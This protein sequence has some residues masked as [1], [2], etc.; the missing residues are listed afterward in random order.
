M[1]IPILYYPSMMPYHKTNSFIILNG[2]ET[3]KLPSFKDLCFDD[4]DHLLVDS[5]PG[6]RWSEQATFGFASQNCKDQFDSETINLPTVKAKNS[7]IGVMQNFVVGCNLVD[8]IDPEFMFHL[9][10]EERDKRRAKHASCL[11]RD[12]DKWSCRKCILSPC[13]PS[14]CNM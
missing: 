7:I 9:N 4:I 13:R 3:E 2:N 12:Y 8:K 1:G 11:V 6:Q 14:G 5:C 10:E